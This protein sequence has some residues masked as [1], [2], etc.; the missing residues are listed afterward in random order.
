MRRFGDGMGWDG[1]GGKCLEGLEGDWAG[2]IDFSA[3]GGGKLYE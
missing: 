2:L 3:M 1:M